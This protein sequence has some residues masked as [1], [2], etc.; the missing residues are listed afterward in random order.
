L[1]SARAL[2]DAHDGAALVEREHAFLEGLDERDHQQV[3]FLQ[4]GQAIRQLLGHAMQGRR[5][6]A[7]LSWSGQRGPPA[8]ISVGDRARDV[9][10]LDHGLRDASRKE[11]GEHERPGQCDE[12]ARQDV[13]LRPVD[14]LLQPRR[15]ERHAHEAEWM[16]DGDVQ[17]LI[18]GRGAVPHRG[19]DRVGAGRDDLG[20][21]RV[22]LQPAPGIRPELGV[23]GDLAGTVDQRDAVPERLSRGVS[24]RIRIDAR[25]PLRG[26]EARAP[27][28]LIDLHLHKTIL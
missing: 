2:V 3:V 11:D 12:S 16:T 13:A 20:T 9:T 8:E 21:I 18:A 17:L 23:A 4:R 25:I 26:D 24:E 5:E 7:D 22:I 15:D 19:T 14:D 6:V 27:G 1:S 28:E 10:Q